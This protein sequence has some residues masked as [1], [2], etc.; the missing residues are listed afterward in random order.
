MASVKYPDVSVQL[1]GMDGNV[2]L[3]IGLVSKA[4]KRAGRREAAQDF[5]NAAMSCGSYDEVL[6]LAM[7]TVDVN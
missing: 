3:I 1:S 2:Y 7:R 5:K 4:L 6:Q